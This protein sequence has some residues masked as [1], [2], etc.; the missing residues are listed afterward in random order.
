MSFHTDKKGNGPP[1]GIGRTKVTRMY[2]ASMNIEILTRNEIEEIIR[3]YYE[4]P[5]MERKDIA[6]ELGMS[7]KAFDKFIANY[8]HL[9]HKIEGVAPK[10]CPKECKNFIKGVR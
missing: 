5:L 4:P 3:T 2:I 1:Y 8:P 10:Y 9:K 6:N 7:L